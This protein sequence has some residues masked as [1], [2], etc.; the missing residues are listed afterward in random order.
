MSADPSLLAITLAAVRIADAVALALILLFALWGMRR[1]ALRQ[2]LSL[3]VLVGSLAV[4][5]WLGPQAEAT[6]AKVTSL[7]GEAREAAA[8]VA[9]LF[10]SL[11]VGGVAL[12]FA[13]CRMPDQATGRSN[14]M[15]G[16]LL[17]GVKG[18]LVL[19]VLAYVLA[20]G[21]AQAGP[22]L[23]R[24]AEPKAPASDTSP[25]VGRLRGSMAASVM[26]TGSRWLGGVVEL[27]TWI[28]RRRA[29]VDEA[30]QS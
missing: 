10:A 5:A 30:L 9:V 8:W 16:A 21:S 17:G 4:A 18:V 14:R 12:S 23:S 20:S 25:W 27:P 6:V 1:G 3:G 22:A 11:V 7:S 19:T 15:L 2:S 28:E 24:T 13:C 29:A 26:A